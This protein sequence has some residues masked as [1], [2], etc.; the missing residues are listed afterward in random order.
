MQQLRQTE[1]KQEEIY[2]EERKR[3]ERY[4]AGPENMITTAIIVEFVSGMHLYQL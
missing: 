2:L 1:I 4:E 3:L